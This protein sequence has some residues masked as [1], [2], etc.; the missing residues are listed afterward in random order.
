MSTPLV[1]IDPDEELTK[2][3]EIMKAKNVRKLPVVKDGII[4]GIITARDITDHF[5]EY[6]DT[7]IRELLVW[8]PLRF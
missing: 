4:Y 6:V 1:S 5:T 3:A 2:A 8:T 7:A